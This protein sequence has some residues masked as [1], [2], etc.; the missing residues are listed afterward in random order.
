MLPGQ[1]TFPYSRA[2]LGNLIFILVF[3]RI[4]FFI[5]VMTLIGTIEPE[6]GSIYWYIASR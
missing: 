5:I 1:Q 2:P 6:G 3:A 4:S